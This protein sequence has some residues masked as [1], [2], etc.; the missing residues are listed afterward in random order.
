MRLVEIDLTI[1]AQNHPELLPLSINVH[2]Q[3]VS[4]QIVLALV[5]NSLVTL[6]RRLDQLVDIVVVC[7]TRLHVVCLAV[8]EQV[9]VEASRR[10]AVGQ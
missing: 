6:S 4:K 3:I 9:V 1:D 5:T 2:V 8:L 7:H 10:R